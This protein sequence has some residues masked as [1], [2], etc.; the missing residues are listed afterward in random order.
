MAPAISEL[1]H[2]GGFYR[3]A[4]SSLQTASPETPTM[5]S[6]HEE[7]VDP[8]ATRNLDLRCQMLKIDRQCAVWRAEEYKKLLERFCGGVGHAAAEPGCSSRSAL[9]GLSNTRAFRQPPRLVALQDDGRRERRQRSVF[10][11]VH[12]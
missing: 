1:S 3:L 5:E 10:T 4:F 8:L 2:A 6:H 11:A 9:S 7:P 12:I